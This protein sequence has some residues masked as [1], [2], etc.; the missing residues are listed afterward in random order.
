MNSVGAQRDL[1]TMVHE[2]GHAVHSFL[3]REL[4][5]TGFK[6]L[7]SEVAELASMSMEL[8][9]ME[10][11]DEFYSNEDD[12]K[13]AKKEQLESILK[14]LPWIAQ[15]DEF[16]HCVYENPTHSHEE[17]SKK[18]VELS[19]S[20]GTGL[21]DWT[22]FEEVQATSWQRQLHLFEVPFYYIEYG[23]A[24]LGALGVWKN[25]LINKEKAIEDYKNAL[26]LGYTRSIPKIYET[27]GIRFDFSETYLK[28]LADFVGIELESL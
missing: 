11:W 8:L 27:A 18:W 4:E 2:G 26:R 1:V 24:Q 22:G 28:E 17:R 25:S 7:P 14:I 9:T 23:I 3:S 6:N 5:L 13:R 19:K 15:I 16:Q 20:Y 10:L 21:T 12:F